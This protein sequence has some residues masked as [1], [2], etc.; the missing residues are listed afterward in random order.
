MS[1]ATGK[2]ELSVAEYVSTDPRC[3]VLSAHPQQILR[4]AVVLN[5]GNGAGLYWHIVSTTCV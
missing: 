5:E 4:L 2:S 1:P 3:L